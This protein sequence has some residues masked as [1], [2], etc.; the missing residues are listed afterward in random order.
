LSGTNLHYTSA[1]MLHYP[2]KEARLGFA[3]GKLK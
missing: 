1:P 2:K 3:N